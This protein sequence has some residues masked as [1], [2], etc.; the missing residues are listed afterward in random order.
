MELD[1]GILITGAKGFI[2]NRLRGSGDRLL[3]R[4]DPGA[5]GEVEGDL[6]C[7]KSL[8]NACRGIKTVFHC[9]GYSDA[10]SA[11]DPQAH[12]RVNYEG[13][14]NLLEAACGAGVRRFIFLSSVKA[15]AEPGDLCV[16]EDWAGQ[17]E[18][19]YGQSKRAAEEAVLEAG[20]RHGMH[21]VNLR[22]AMVY[23]RG[24]HGNLERMAR[25]IEKRL[26][27]P[28]PE[29]GNRRSLVHVDDVVR[30]VRLVA[31][32]PEANGRTYIIADPQPY[33]GRQIYSAIRSALGAPAAKWAVPAA[34]L[35]GGGRLGDLL[36]KVSGR[37]LP[38]NSEVVE[39][40]LGSACYNPH[41]IEKELGFRAQVGLE[42]GLRE[43]LS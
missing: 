18:T 2:G 43:M 31:S 39:R 7:T 24:G 5:P 3:V 15:M 17:P 22:L 27:P 29:T 30:A 12:W 19:P 42:Q 28:L 25:M 38:L 41:L 37:Q 32:R 34:W 26:F 10:M 35:R 33:S 21:V 4:R 23:G 1:S 13:T 16:D 14:R 9:A 20:A 11:S 36:G 40:L 8:A 6:L